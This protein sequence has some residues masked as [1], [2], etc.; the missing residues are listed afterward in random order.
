[1][2]CAVVLLAVGADEVGLAEPALLEDRDDGVVV[3]VDVDPVADVGAGAVQLG[4]DALQDAGDLARDELLDVLARAVVVRAVGQ[5]GRDAERADPRPHQQVGARPWSR[6][7]GCEGLT[8]VGSVNRVR[9]V[10]LEVAV[11]LVGGDVVQPHAVPAH[12]L[13]Q[14]VGADDVGLHERP[15]VVQ[16][17]C[18]CATRRRSAPPRRCRR[19]AGRPASASATLPSTKRICVGDRSARL[20]R[21]CRRRS[22][23]PATVTCQSGAASRTRWTKFAPMKPAPPVTRT[24]MADLLAVRCVRRPVAVGGVR[25]RRWRASGSATVR[26]P[27]GSSPGGQPL[28]STSRLNRWAR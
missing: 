20:A 26:R 15:R 23:R 12:R 9:V 8:G 6:S 18:R 10:E 3:V 27:G 5:R 28:N 16:A 24:F 11:D 19:R 1:M 4:L 7:R 14:P 21:G 13:E 25:V 2:I 17:S 22:A